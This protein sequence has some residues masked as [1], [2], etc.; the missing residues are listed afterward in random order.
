MGYIL[1][2]LIRKFAESN[3]TQAGDHFTPRE[4]IALMVDILFHTQDDVLTKPGTVRTIYEPAAGTGGMLSTAYDHLV[5][6]NLKARPVLYLENDVKSE[7]RALLQYA[8][9]LNYDLYWDPQPVFVED[10]FLGNREYLWKTFYVSKMVLA[11]PGEKHLIPPE[12]IPV[13]EGPEQWWWF[14]S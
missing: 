7:S 5:E 8:F 9:D 13:V 6:M 11:L 2:E 4:V 1:E 12:G 3:S 10:N 14:G